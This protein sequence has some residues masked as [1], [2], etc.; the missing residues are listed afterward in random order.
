MSR[1]G[2]DE[3]ALEL[4]ELLPGEVEKYISLG[5]LD[6]GITYLP[7]PC[8]DLDFLKITSIEMGV[9]TKAG[10]FEN[11]PQTELPFVI[12]VTPMHATPTRVRGLDGWPDDAYPRKVLHRVTLLESALELCRQGRVA[13]Y[14][15]T[16]IVREHNQRVRDDLRLERRKSPYTGRICRSDVYL[17]KRKS[18]EETT[19]AKQ[20]A[21]AIRLICCH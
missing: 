11:V 2:W 7:V 5:E 1:I 19:V 3:N 13:G 14:F 6:F 15:P 17:V 9:F 12:P 21:K 18:Y 10:A 8:P 4:H 20:L 16:F